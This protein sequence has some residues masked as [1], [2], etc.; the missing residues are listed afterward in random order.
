MASWDIPILDTALGDDLLLAVNDAVTLNRSNWYGATDPAT[1]GEATAGMWW[2][3]SGNTEVKLRSAVSTW[4][5]AG[6]YESNLGMIR[7]DGSNTMNGALR[8]GLNRLEFSSSTGGDAIEAQTSG[9]IN[10]RIGGT[11]EAS[12]TASTFDL[13]SNE[14]KDPARDASA[15]GAPTGT[16]PFRIYINIGG[17]RYYVPAYASF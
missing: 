7:R 2:V 15:V 6:K 16:P 14:I 9:T 13:F 5:T 11:V 17:T 12:L 1:A 10:L 4:F 3:D 8:M